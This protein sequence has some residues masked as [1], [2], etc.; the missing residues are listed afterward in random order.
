MAGSVLTLPEVPLALVLALLL[1][2]PGSEP[3][4]LGAQDALSSRVPDKQS[5]CRLYILF[6]GQ[7]LLDVI[8]YTL[9]RS[10]LKDCNLP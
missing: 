9:P 6:T 1:A 2:V 3:A 7:L 10:G 8:F 5:V 4:A